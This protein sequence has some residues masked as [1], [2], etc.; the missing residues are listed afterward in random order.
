V[1]SSMDE[2]LAHALAPMAAMPA[3]H[4]SQTAH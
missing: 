2:V 1:V 4:A 3:V